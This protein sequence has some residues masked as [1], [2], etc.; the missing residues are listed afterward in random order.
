MRYRDMNLDLARARRLDLQE[1]KE[2]TEDLAAGA[3]GKKI[4]ATYDGTYT[5]ALVH[6]RQLRID[7]KGHVIRRTLF[8]TDNNGN[9]ISG[10]KRY[11]EHLLQAPLY[12]REAAILENTTRTLLN[13]TKE[14]KRKNKAGVRFCFSLCPTVDRA[15]RMYRKRSI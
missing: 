9:E 6:L 7:L 5:A 4:T 15:N 1:T 13:Q 14:E 2:N 3:R 8:S 11:T 12:P 10:M